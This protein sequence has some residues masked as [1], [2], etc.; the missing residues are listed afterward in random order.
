MKILLAFLSIAMVAALGLTSAVASPNL[1]GT[2]KLYNAQQ[3]KD[4]IA[5]GAQATITWTDPPLHGGSYSAHRVAVIQISPWRYAEIGWYKYSAG[6]FTFVTCE[7]GS[8]PQ[9]DLFPVSPATHEYAFQYDPNGAQ[10]WFYVD[11]SVVSHK[12]VNFSSGDRVA[13]GGEVYDGV[14][15]MG[16]TRLFNLRYLINVG[17]SFYYVPWDGYERYM[18]EF[19]YCN[20][21][22]DP[23]SFYDTEWECYVLLPLVLKMW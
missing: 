10:H 14:E 22:I 8:G 5:W 11:S 6:L 15:S 16:R 9:M 4:L 23:N 19:P 1:Q 17:G 7:D 20:I 13:A 2:K 12:A 3:K 18:I 21:A